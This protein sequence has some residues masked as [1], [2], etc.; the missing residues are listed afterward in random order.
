MKTTTL[1]WSGRCT[2]IALIV[3]QPLIGWPLYTLAAE[4]APTNPAVKSP[5][6]KPPP[7]S[8]VTESQAV[9]QANR[10][11]PKVE[12]PSGFNLA[13]NPTDEEITQCG[14]FSEPLVPMSGSAERTDNQAL[15]SAL[16]QYA[17][18]SAAEDVSA[19]TGFCDQY[20]QSRWRVGLFY[21][22][23]QIYYF[24]GYYS[25]AL[26]AWEQ[27]WDEGKTASE[28]GAMALVNQ[29]FA[30]LGR[31]NARLGRTARLEGLLKEGQS[32]EFLGSSAQEV[33]DMKDALALMRH[34]PDHSFRCGP[35]AL[36]EIRA[37]QHIVDS[38]G[39][40]MI[41]AAK[42]TSQGCS[43]LQVVN[44]A[45]SAGMKYQAAKRDPGALLITPAV[46]HWKLG[47][48]AAL[49]KQDH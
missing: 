9:V 40:Q 42:S 45:E 20:P 34:D 29:A 14:L 36:A 3:L 47:H 7:S 35:L 21:N 13:Q 17:T 31:M 10:T 23:G 16:N 25:K 37:S 19:L 39:D 38:A 8:P 27:A 48:Y 12:S 33:V 2:A 43:L 4:V 15:S 32:R 22:L 49:V 5:A 18:R 44:L 24:E 1:G 28:P 11:V 30:E 26:A 46:V 6:L 41:M